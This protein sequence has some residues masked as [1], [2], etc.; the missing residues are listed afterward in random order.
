M[1]I[2]SPPPSADVVVVG[3]GTA[4]LALA[5]R[6]SKQKPNLDILVIESGPN[7]SGHPFTSHPSGAF[8]ACGSELDWS[9][10][11][12][13]Q[14]ALNDRVLHLSA[15]KALSGATAIN[16]GLWLRGPAADYDRWAK[17]V[18]DES[19]SY[20]GLLPYFK[21]LEKHFD[22]DGDREQHGFDGPMHTSSVSRSDPTRRYPLREKV[23][24][25]WKEI[26]VNLIPDYNNG[27]PLGLG[28]VVENWHNGIRQPAH[29]TLDLSNV[30]ILCGVTVSRVLVE[31]VTSKRATGVE[32][33]DGTWVCAKREVI[34]STGTYRTPQVL[35]LSGIGP[36]PILYKYNIPAHVDNP[37]VGRNMHDHLVVPLFWKVRNP[38]LGVAAG[39]P[40]FNV[41]GF[42]KG[43]PFDYVAYRQAPRAT[44]EQALKAD[45]E[46]EA[47]PLD[48]Q[49]LLDQERI[50]TESLV[51]YLP[52]TRT[53]PLPLDGTVIT[54]SVLCM[55][56]TSRGTVTI[57]SADPAA[58]PAIDSN[59]YSTHADRAILRDGVRGALNLMQSTRAGT[60]MVEREIPPQSCPPLHH[61]DSS[62]ED[63]DARVRHA[64]EIYNHPGGTAAMGKVVDSHC[65]VIGVQGLRV[66]DASILPMP[67]AAHYMICVYALGER[68]ADF[69]AEDL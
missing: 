2:N 30:K 64:G 58:M 62:D 8:A 59:F 60:S 39:S 12:T 23:R 35:M 21:G 6:L 41:P 4:G 51:T 54:T 3:G 5:A 33:L 38:Q 31:G 43:T 25:A 13:P 57:E 67:I 49:E 9:Y 42:A 61:S 24:D 22:P 53:E 66:A 19:W 29:E 18:G 56:P 44:I 37:E 1:F 52:V 15:G 68:V 20:S 26:G 7:P 55:Q 36:A 50:H 28:E 17:L 32:L 10:K 48:P 34:I 14:K 16:Y 45:R 47:S 63:I 69:M 65:R 40:A 27:H 11:S 46:D